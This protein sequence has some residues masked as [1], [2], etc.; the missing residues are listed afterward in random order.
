M[1]PH[2]CCGGT[3]NFRLMNVGARVGFGLGLCFRPGTK[4]LSSH[5]HG[6]HIVQKIMDCI[7]WNY[8]GFWVPCGW[9]WQVELSPPVWL[10]FQLHKNMLDVMLKT[11]TSWFIFPKQQQQHSDRKPKQILVPAK[12][13]GYLV[14]LKPS[15]SSSHGSSTKSPLPSFLFPQST[16][17]K[18]T[19]TMSTFTNWSRDSALY[20]LN[21]QEEEAN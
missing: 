17:Y 11:H 21:F 2:R 19:M 6:L 3:F 16:Q 5:D 9:H 1:E 7:I 13:S 18:P 12:F 14:S 20:T 4:T 8:N 10:T 15:L